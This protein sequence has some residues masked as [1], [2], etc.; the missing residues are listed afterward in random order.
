MTFRFQIANAQQKR[1][2]MARAHRDVVG[3]AGNPE[4]FR[5][6]MDLHRRTYLTEPSRYGPKL[7]RK[8]LRLQ[9]HNEQYL[10]EAGLI[11]PE[12]CPF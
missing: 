5:F 7:T 3:G 4:D 6:G 12:T 10:R 1:V 8:E 11:D 2:A 9:R